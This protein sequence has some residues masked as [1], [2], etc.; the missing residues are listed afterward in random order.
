[1]SET[2]L[3]F[4][5]KGWVGSIL[6]FL[7]IVL[8]IWFYLK[9][10]RTPKA[11]VHIDASRMVGWGKAGDLPEG[12]SVSFRDV[13]V[14]RISRVLIRLW[15][16]GSATLESNLIPSGE[17]LRLELSSKDSRILTGVLLKQT[18]Q[19]NN[20]SV[21]VDPDN[22]SVLLINFNYFDPGEGVLIGMLHTDSES[23]PIFKGIVKGQRIAIL[24]SNQTRNSISKR[25]FKQTINKTRI[26]EATFLVIGIVFLASAILLPNEIVTKVLHFD[27]V[28]D[29]SAPPVRVRFISA[30]IG[31]SYIF[32]AAVGL[33]SRRRRYPKNLE[34]P[35]NG[36]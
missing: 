9:S 23:T 31:T 17:P 12:V 30:G 35:S 24:D 18:R 1:M 25:L 32:L 2:V 14:P 21:R 26:F 5:S 8:A 19:A 7:G 13:N 22:S 34:K 15:N 27:S 36:E 11:T 16:A 29:S 3:D 20:F 33:W 28:Q 6:G 10:I 4:L